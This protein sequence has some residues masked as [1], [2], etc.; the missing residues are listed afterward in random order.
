V[1]AFALY[2]QRL[3]SGGI[4]GTEKRHKAAGLL[5]DAQCNWEGYPRDC[6]L[7][8]QRNITTAFVTIKSGAAPDP[9]ESAKLS[10][11]WTGYVLHL[12]NEIATIAAFFTFCPCV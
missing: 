3:N 10:H 6:K 8:S 4:F 7:V 5:V 2:D 9:L 1:V 12:N 11:I